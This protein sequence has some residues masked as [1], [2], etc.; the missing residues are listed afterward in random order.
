MAIYLSHED[1]KGLIRMKDVLHAAEQ[2][3]KDLGHGS[4]TNLPRQRL[5]VPKGV[6]RV[7]S[8]AVPSLG[9]MGS[10]GGLHQFAVPQGIQKGYDVNVLYSSETGELLAL[11]RT[12]LITDYRTGAM[13]AVSTKYL[14]RSDANVVGVLGSGRQARTQLAAVAL[15]RPLK[16][17]LVYSP[18]PEHRI[19]YA[20]EMSRELDLDVSPTEDP[21]LV[22]EAADVLIAATKLLQPIQWTPSL[23]G[24]G[25]K[26]EPISFRFVPPT[27]WILVS[28]QRGG[29]LMTGQ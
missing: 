23:M 19:G 9:G 17:V 4:A 8:G 18:N 29:R 15:V 20:N 28:G 11:I 13:G 1:V 5:G 27:S 25:F 6:Y 26:K 14:A 16:R 21:G 7:M 24:T 2:A 3:F 10:K 12:S 22:V